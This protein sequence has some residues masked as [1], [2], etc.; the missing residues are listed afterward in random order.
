MKKIK[1][2]N[3]YLAFGSNIGDRKKN[4]EKAFEK[5]K[6]KNIRLIKKS[7]YY[8]TSP[9]GPAQ[10]F[11]YNL[12]AKFRTSLTPKDLLII[13]KKI[14][15]DLG[16]QKTIK[17]GPRIIDIDIL[18]YSDKIIRQKNII[19]PHKEIKNR[20]FVLYPLAEISPSLTHPNYKKQIKTLL[21]KAL[22]ESSDY[23]KKL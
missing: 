19:I 23:I 21:N 15:A 7:S 6:Q 16:R 9:V 4:I 11:F 1:Y 13:L 8:K 2:V 5:L 10:R 22:T 18:F 3:V 12:A 17:W 14:E 20:L